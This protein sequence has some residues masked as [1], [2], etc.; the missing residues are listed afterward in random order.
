[1]LEDILKGVLVNA[2]GKYVEGIDS[3]NLS[4]GLLSGKIV[5]DNCRLKSSYI[6]KLNLPFKI[7]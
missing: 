4:V 7:Q 5:L 3:K 6:N 2:L 1:M